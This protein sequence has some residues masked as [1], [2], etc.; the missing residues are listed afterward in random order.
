M[1]R[2]RPLRA[3]NFIIPPFEGF[4]KRKIKNFVEK[5]F[6]KTLTYFLGCVIL[7]MQGGIE[8]LKKVLTW[9][10]ICITNE[11]TLEQK[12]ILLKKLLTNK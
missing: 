5:I 3:E 2:V 1:A 11:F 4:V 7:I 9:E 8:M 12:I 10:D 6:P